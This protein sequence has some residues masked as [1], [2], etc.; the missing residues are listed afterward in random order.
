MNNAITQS[1]SAAEGFFE[2]PLAKQIILFVGIAASIAVAMYFVMWSKQPDYVPLFSQLSEK[3]ASEVVDG[4]QR[5]NIVFKIDEKSGT[6]LV[7]ASKAQEARIRLASS[8]IPASAASGFEVLDKENVFG[9]SQ[10]VERARY[11]KALEGELERTISSIGSIKSARV[12]LALPKQ[13]SFLKDKREPSASVFIDIQG[14]Y[15]LESE[16][17]EAITHLVASSI[18]GLSAQNVTVIDQNGKLLSSS[19]DDSFSVASKQL[20]YTH[21]LES[22]YAQRIHDLLVPMIGYDRVKAEVTANVDFVSW[23]ETSENYD[24]DKKVIRSERT[25]ETERMLNG[26]AKGIPGALS[27]QP[28]PKAQ[29]TPMTNPKDKKPSVTEAKP[30]AENISKQA[31]IN[32]EIDRKIKHQ[33]NSPGKLLRLSVAVI[34][35]DK[36]T[37]GKDGK[38]NKKPLTPEE[39]E[40]IEKLIK[41]AIGFDKERGDKVTVVNSAFAQAEPI[42][43]LPKENIMEKIPFFAISKQ[44]IAVGTILIIIFL[45]LRPIIRNLTNI[46]SY[47]KS[48]M[49]EIAMSQE[50]AMANNP[51]LKTGDDFSVKIKE[52][53][54]TDPQKAAQIIKQ[55]VG[56]IN[57]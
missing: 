33:L 56:N 32:Y 41:D 42:A 47:K 25:S 40:K 21:K 31:T 54:H 2:L 13:T 30:L 12:H 18:Q 17:V 6:V 28:P 7:D 9:A 51:N 8:G 46:S 11:V 34:V 48:I 53:V 39:M 20:E 1:G 37:Y 38:A 57:D 29:D 14:R 16:Q 45:V 19:G 43:P 49:K 23:E 15:R 10:L 26:A 55:W 3:D 5:A 24:P 44:L 22:M 36:V 4:L 27:N 50:E 35:D 52:L